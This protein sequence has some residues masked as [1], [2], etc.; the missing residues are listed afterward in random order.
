MFDYR[1]LVAERNYNYFLE[2]L[3]EY[4]DIYKQQS[5]GVLNSNGIQE[6]YVK[7]IKAIVLTEG[8]N[9]NLMNNGKQTNTN[10]VSLRTTEDN[11]INCYFTR[12]KKYGGLKYKITSIDKTEGIVNDKMLYYYVATRS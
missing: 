5:S 8:E 4:I 2:N 9:N 1:K 12:D 11:L 3:G 6:V 10:H 7:T